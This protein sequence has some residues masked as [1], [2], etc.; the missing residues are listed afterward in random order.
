MLAE[1]EFCQTYFDRLMNWD[2][3]NE[4]VF[5]SRF[6]RITREPLEEFV[7]ILEFLGV[8]VKEGV[9]P[10]IPIAIDKAIS[11]L[12]GAPMRVRNYTCKGY[13]QRALSLHAYKKK[14]KGR[15]AGQEDKS[16]HFRKGVSGDWKNYFSPKVKHAFKERYPGLV[17]HTGYEQSDD[18]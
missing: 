5:E 7:K 9:L 12:T 1:V 11:K 8:E 17:V 10:M 18:W 3:N 13:L 15:V 4:F 2:F 6:D 16:S 14:A